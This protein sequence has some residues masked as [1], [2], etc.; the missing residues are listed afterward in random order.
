M[1][2][3]EKIVLALS[4]EMPR[5]QAPFM[6]FHFIMFALIILA[7][8]LVCLKFKN[9]SDKTFRKIL[10]IIW[11]IL[12]VFEIYKQIVSPFSVVDGK[13]VWKYN[14]NDIP[15]QFCSSIHYVLLP[16]VFL[17]DGKVRN[18]FISFTMTFVFLAGAMVSIFPDQLRSDMAIGICI[19]TMVHHGLQVVAGAFIAVKMREKYSIKFFLS[20]VIVFF[21]F[22][23]LALTFNLIFNPSVTNGNVINF[24]Y[25][26]PYY[27]CSL[28]ILSEIRQMVPWGVFIVIYSLGFVL[29]SFAIFMAYVGIKKL[30]K[31]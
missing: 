1:N 9:C 26:S 19:Q 16:I 4:A 8:V 28:P 29:I 21:G 7:T 25:I 13:A 10:F 3:F 30:S 27:G 15:F 31:K 6:P 20:G 17:K 14:F 22:L 11:I 2:T 12:F 23:A 24:F 18:A 5:V